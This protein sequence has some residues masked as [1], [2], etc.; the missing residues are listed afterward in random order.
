M[1]SLTPGGRPELS[2][3]D[4][5]PVPAGLP[6]G[7]CIMTTLYDEN[8]Q[9]TG[10]RIDRADPR[11]LISAELLI[12][13][14]HGYIPFVPFASVELQPGACGTVALYIGALLK[15]RGVNRT[16]IYRITDFVPRVSGYIGEWPD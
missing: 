6:R 11:I 16:V 15:I 2:V 13:I 5:L 12:A 9:R 4:G 10:I 1:T 8:R 3:A 14:A 7:E